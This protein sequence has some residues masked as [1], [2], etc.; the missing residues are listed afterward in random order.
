MMYVV[1]SLFLT[2]LNADLFYSRKITKIFQYFHQFIL[3]FL[4]L[5]II[6]NIL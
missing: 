6:L 5:L 4:T 2:D 3:I 1:V